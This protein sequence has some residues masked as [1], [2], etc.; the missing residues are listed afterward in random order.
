MIRSI[1]VDALLEWMNRHEL[2]EDGGIDFN[3]LEEHINKMAVVRNI[4]PEDTIARQD[5]IMALC[6]T[7]TDDG[8][9][10]RDCKMYQI[11]I[12]ADVYALETVPESEAPARCIASIKIDKDELVNWFKKEYGIEDKAKRHPGEWKHIATIHS[13]EYGE[14][15]THHIWECS[16]CDYEGNPDWPYC[17][18]CGSPMA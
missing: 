2:T 18:H 8:E 12:C 15:R 14:I 13:N 6:R 11:G 4:E 17:P 10:Y 5:A 1:N 7:C 9:Y 3:E 16:E